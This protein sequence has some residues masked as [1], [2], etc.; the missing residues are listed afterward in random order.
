MKR[1]LHIRLEILEG[2]AFDETLRELRRTPLYA[3]RIQR[4]IEKRCAALKSL[5][6]E[7]KAACAQ[8]QEEAILLTQRAYAKGQTVDASKDFPSPELCG[9]F[10]YSIPVCAS[11]TAKPVGRRL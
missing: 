11:S 4:A 1:T 10:V 8:A 5:Q 3:H 2:D 7:R 9:G 6:G